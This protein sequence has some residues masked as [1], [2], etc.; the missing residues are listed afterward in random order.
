MTL[1]PSSSRRKLSSLL[2]LRVCFFPRL[3]CPPRSAEALL[4]LCDAVLACKWCAPARDSSRCCS[5]L[6]VRVLA[7]AAQTSTEI[8]ETLKRVSAYAGEPHANCL[9]QRARRAACLFQRKPSRAAH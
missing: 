2:P 1:L 3:L 4:C 9:L 8:E 5:G 6:T 7:P